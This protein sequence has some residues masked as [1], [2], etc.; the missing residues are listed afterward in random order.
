MH[1]SATGF[2]MPE[3]VAA[4]TQN[5]LATRA[6]FDQW[7]VEIDQWKDEVGAVGALALGEA[8]ARKP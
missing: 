3:V 5:G 7:R 2:F 6:Q 8:I 4:A 1:S